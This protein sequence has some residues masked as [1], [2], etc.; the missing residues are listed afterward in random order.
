MTQRRFRG[1]PCS[2]CGSVH[3]ITYGS[4]KLM[5]SLFHDIV[6][7]NVI[8]VNFVNNQLM[9]N[10]NQY[11]QQAELLII[12]HVFVANIVTC[13]DHKVAKFQNY[14]ILL[15]FGGSIHHVLDVL[16][17]VRLDYQTIQY[18]VGHLQMTLI[19]I[20]KDVPFVIYVINLDVIQMIHLT[21]SNDGPQNKL[22][23]FHMRI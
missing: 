14:I 5:V 7:E 22:M 17:V 13:M 8:F 18:L 11:K 23:V 19:C 16:H 9:N 21:E 15:E 1:N 3:G 6:K 20:I 2:V 10:E 12:H 4:S